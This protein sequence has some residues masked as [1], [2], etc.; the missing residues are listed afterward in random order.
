VHQARVEPAT[1]RSPV[2]HA[3][4]ISSVVA[5]EFYSCLF[6]IQSMQYLQV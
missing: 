1:L 5:P 4:S 3:T 6:S 2:Q